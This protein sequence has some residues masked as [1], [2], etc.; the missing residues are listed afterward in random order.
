MDIT[1]Q[2]YHQ[3]CLETVLGVVPELASSQVCWEFRYHWL[4]SAH[5][6]DSQQMVWWSPAP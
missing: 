2:A 5:L 6:V 3:S 4:L 1:I